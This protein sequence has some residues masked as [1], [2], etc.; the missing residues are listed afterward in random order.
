MNRIAISIFIWL[1]FFSLPIYGEYVGVNCIQPSPDYILSGCISYYQY[2]ECNVIMDNV[3]LE[4]NPCF[5]LVQEGYDVPTQFPCETFECV[6]LR[7]KYM[8][9]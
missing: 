7:T 4:E 8:D 3:C 5:C 1:S 6:W 2:F 9:N